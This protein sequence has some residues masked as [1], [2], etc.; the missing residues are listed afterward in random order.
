M[1]ETAPERD[2]LADAEDVTPTDPGETEGKETDIP[3]DPDTDTEEHP[4]E[5]Y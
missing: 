4:A 5:G 3:E 2:P 1:T